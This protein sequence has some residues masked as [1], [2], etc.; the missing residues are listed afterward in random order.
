MSYLQDVYALHR[1]DFQCLFTPTHEPERVTQ[2]LDQLQHP[3]GNSREPIQ[4]VTWR[5]HEGLLTTLPNQDRVPLAPSG[6]RAS[7]TQDPLGAL[8]A[9][10]DYGELRH[11]H[12]LP[13]SALIVFY[14]FDHYF[15]SPDVA[16]F[17]Q[18]TARY[19][20]LSRS[21][22]D[23]SKQSQ[24]SL[25]F[26]QST[27]VLP[28]SIRSVFRRVDLALPTEEELTAMVQG[29]VAESQVWRIA[30]GVTP[31]IAR[32][33]RGMTE[34]DASNAF[35]LVLLEHGMRH[36]AQ[37]PIGDDCLELIEQQKAL[38]L[39][40]STL[41][42]IP[43]SQLGVDVSSLAGYEVLLQYL[44]EQKQA[45]SREARDL[46]I[47][48]PKGFAVIGLPGTA[49]T[50]AA[51]LTGSVLGLP[52]V[53][54]DVGSL[55]RSQVGGTEAQWREVVRL[56][57]AM[58]GVVAVFDE[59][60]KM[61]A[62]MGN[63]QVVADSGVGRRLFGMILQWLSSKQDGTYVVVTIN[64]HTSIPPEFYRAG[65]LDMLFGVG[66]PDDRVRRQILE[67][68][69]RRRGVDPA[70]LRLNAAEWDRVV[71]ATE[72]MVGSEIEEIVKAS[73]LRQFCL[74]GTG[75][76]SLAIIMEIIDRQRRSC[77]SAM[78]SETIN[79]LK[80]HISQRTVLVSGN[81]PAGTSVPSSGR[82]QRRRVN[83]N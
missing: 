78:D 57:E 74:N 65:R 77:L 49:K 30:P 40:G 17:L 16:A 56:L 47:D 80:A 61:F 12:G 21:T 52:V 69:F 3:G 2:L 83:E 43:R 33:L 4:I 71:A 48:A 58:H 27:D 37:T 36:G 14:D 41:Q 6:G 54:I 44:E 10:R 29:I 64:D 15:A 31:R 13:R 67:T 45:L 22:G 24:V 1:A 55:F 79:K 66:M 23:A 28:A 63:A 38:S 76:P 8:R 73:R 35:S 5:G 59:A 62:G 42:Y 50:M 51:K 60:E 68:H 25:L 19:R 72:G 34:S 46:K 75:V 20:H 53:I 82:P 9:V 70:E 81:A 18:Y 32:A 26:I 39:T 7:D 11:V